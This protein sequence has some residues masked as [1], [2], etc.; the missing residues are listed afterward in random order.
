MDDKFNDL[1][2]EIR[3][4][5]RLDYIMPEDI[6]D[7]ELYMDQVIRFMDVHLQRSDR[8][9]GEDDKTLTKTMINNYTKNKILPPP[10]KKKYSKEHII[11][12]ISIYYLKNIASI[13]DIRKLLDPMMER[14]FNKKG[15][16]GRSLTEVYS[17]IFNLE[18]RQYF[19]I[20]NSIIRADEIA[21]MKM[22]EEDDEYLKKMTLVYMLAYDIYSKKRYMEHLIDEIDESEKKR[23][24][25]EKAKAVRASVKCAAKKSA[26]MDKKVAA[27]KVAAKK[28]AAGKTAVRKASVS[29]TGERIKQGSTAKS[30]GRANTD[31]K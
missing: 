22:P 30:S 31:A 19:N 12:L 6:P 7:I 4:L 16:D 18:R 27:R 14:Y 25:K 24:A 26:A 2:K 23:K 21:E 13:S 17:E 20:E 9:D 29:R 8:T 28:T 11:M 10:E 1:K 3:R 15:E 5:I